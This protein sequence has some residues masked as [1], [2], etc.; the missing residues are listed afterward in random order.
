MPDTAIAS[1]PCPAPAEF[2][3]FRGRK[4]RFY[5]AGCVPS[6]QGRG[7]AAPY[8]QPEDVE[9]AETVGKFY[10]GPV[11]QCGDEIE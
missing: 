11:R 8:V 2:I 3:V 5:C 7:R 10:T 4:R 9:H 6:Y 1:A